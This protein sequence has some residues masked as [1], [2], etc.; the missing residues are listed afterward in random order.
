MHSLRTLM[1]W[2]W[3]D[4]GALEAAMRIGQTIP[5]VFPCNEAWT[6]AFRITLSCMLFKLRHV[7]ESVTFSNHMFGGQKHVKTHQKSWFP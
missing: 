2:V 3:H 6:N 5:Q 4:E 7:V 1:P